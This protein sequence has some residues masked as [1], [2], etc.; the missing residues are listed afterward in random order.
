MPYVSHEPAVESVADNMAAASG[1]QQNDGT[2]P[3]I[4]QSAPPR[5]DDRAD[6]IAGQQ[7]YGGDCEQDKMQ[8]EPAVQGHR[9]TKGGDDDVIIVREDTIQQAS[10]HIQKAQA[11]RNTDCQQRGPGAPGVHWA[12]PKP[13]DTIEGP[14]DDSDMALW[15]SRWF[16]TATT[17]SIR[18]MWD[19]PKQNNY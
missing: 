15:A 18:R 3:N 8:A 9:E 19:Q 11:H 5:P 6:D 1:V 7:P 16:R 14:V 12:A 2:G 13:R 4:T 10:R 17:S